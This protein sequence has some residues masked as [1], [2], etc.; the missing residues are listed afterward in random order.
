MS[1]DC[2]VYSVICIE[3]FL[4]CALLP[5]CFLYLDFALYF[6]TCIFSPFSSPRSVSFTFGLA[7]VG[8]PILIFSSLTNKVTTKATTTL[9]DVL[10][11][12]TDF[13]GSKFAT[14]GKNATRD[15]DGDNILSS[16]K[17]LY[18]KGKV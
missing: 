15:N 4:K 16:F 8:V 10:E 13:I 12:N 9:K 17:T 3:Y 7:K 18:K 5:M 1:R 6:L 11:R 2:L 14:N